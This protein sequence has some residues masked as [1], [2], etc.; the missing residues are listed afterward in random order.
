MLSTFNSDIAPDFSRLRSCP[1]QEL[2][3]LVNANWLFPW[4]LS[5]HGWPLAMGA[6]PL[7][8]EQPPLRRPMNMVWLCCCPN[9]GSMVHKAS[10][11]LS[12]K[13]FLF[14]STILSS[15]VQTVLLNAFVD[16]LVDMW[17]HDEW[18]PFIR[19]FT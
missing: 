13:A 8:V 9:S 12:G 2:T 1:H 18:F 7:A 4:W 10:G 5:P 17:Y 19:Y 11:S 16:P 6:A 15:M 3:I 14:L